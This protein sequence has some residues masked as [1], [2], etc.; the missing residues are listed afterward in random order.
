MWCEERLSRTSG[1]SY[2]PLN[3]ITSLFLILAAYVV[4][5]RER[6]YAVA[7]VITGVGSVLFHAWPCMATRLLDELGIVAIVVLYIGGL[8]ISNNSIVFFR[9]CIASVLLVVCLILPQHACVVLL[10]VAIVITIFDKRL[11]RRSRLSGAGAALVWVLDSVVCP[12]TT[13]DSAVLTFHAIWHA[14]VSMA[15]VSFVVDITATATKQK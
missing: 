9:N 7:M 10:C 15:F 5:D 1:S 11:S 12:I 2:Q 14:A 8:D 13:F 4:A 3:T 6:N